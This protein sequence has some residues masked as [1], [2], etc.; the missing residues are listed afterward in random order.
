VDKSQGEVTAVRVGG[1]AVMVS[2]AIMEIALPRDC[3][4]LAFTVCVRRCPFVSSFT[5]AFASR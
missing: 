2:E 4:A 5:V 1:A 3:V